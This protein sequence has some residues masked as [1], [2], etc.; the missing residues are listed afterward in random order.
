MKKIFS[1]IIMLLVLLEANGQVARPD[2]FHEK[3]TLKQVVVLSRH[4]IRSPLSGP[5]SALGR[6]T[7][8]EWFAWSSAPSELSLRGGV[9][10]TMMG[11]FF[12][13]WL[14]SEGLM[15]ENEVPQEGVMRF[16]ANSMQR[17]I[18]TAQYFSSGM[19]PVANVN[20]EHH[21]SIGTMDPVF[22]PVI[23][24]DDETFRA[25]V[26]QEITSRY[27][28]GSMSGIG[29]ALSKNYQLLAEVLDL[30]QSAAC[31]QGDTCS[32]KTDDTQIVLTTGKE[33]A[34]KGSLSLAC[35][36]VDALVLQYYEEPD[37]RKA[38]FGHE[39]SR[40]DWQTLSVIKDYYGDVLFTSPTLSVNLAHPL[41]KEL[42]SELQNG[43]RRFTF[44]C[45]HDSN[46]GSVL[47]ALGCDEYT[48]P[49]SIEKTPI[50]A[51]LVIEKWA[52]S[53][54]EEYV[55]M[56]MVY[57]STDQLRQMPLLSLGNPPVVYNME[58]KGLSANSDG[59]YRLTDF[60]K[61]LTERIEAN[62]T[63]PASV[64]KAKAYHSTS[65]SIYSLQGHRLDSEAQPL[66]I[67]IKE[68]QKRILK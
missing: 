43:Q 61:L 38:A 9:L 50:G 8:H 47:G 15:A 10:E 29:E 3:Y 25:T 51:K 55:A 1:A 17:T 4:N 37:D 54:G 5:E 23:T 42:L 66:G 39:L 32:F 26:L 33:P 24:C 11:Q 22:S 13:K 60:E 44:L 18:A 2:S 58:L 56:N 36:A 21:Y 41:L 40:D 12:R 31:Q 62:G 19:L 53:D 59:L 48:L 27:G 63:T 20:I 16:Y 68:G 35:K 28:N 65:A 34:L 67:Y 49:Q 52:G 14:V 46:L 30:Q 45:G 57:Q 64:H 7:P 6:I